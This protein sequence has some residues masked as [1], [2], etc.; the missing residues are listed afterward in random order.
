MYKGL[1]GL[2]QPKPFEC[3]A[4]YEETKVA[5]YLLT[6]NFTKDK[7]LP[8][9]LKFFSDIMMSKENDWEKRTHKLLT[10]WTDEHRIPNE[11][12]TFREVFNSP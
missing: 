11:L 3:V 5:S 7:Q 12:V 4:T 10:Q 6:K 8:Q 2:T 9:L 1:L